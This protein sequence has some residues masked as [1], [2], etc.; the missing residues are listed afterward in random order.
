MIS[1]DETTW[2]PPEAWR[3]VLHP[4]R[5]GTVVPPPAI[6]ENA[7]ATVRVWLPSAMSR[8]RKIFDEPDTAP[9]LVEAAR[10]WIRGEA[11]PAGAAAI[12][13]MLPEVL[14]TN[15]P[16]AETLV[17]AWIGEHGLV[18][19]AEAAVQTAHVRL[20]SE[21]FGQYDRRHS[22]NYRDVK[23]VP[24]GW[25]SPTMARL[26]A[27]LA[28]TDEQTYWRAV[29]ALAEHRKTD[30]T[31]LMVSFMVP[32]EVHWVD[33][34]V[35]THPMTGYGNRLL[36]TLSSASTTAQIETLSGDP[37]FFWVFPLPISAYTVADG[38]GPALAPVI[39]TELANFPTG[40]TR[41]LLLTIL[42]EFPTDEAFGILLERVGQHLVQPALLAAMN[43]YPRRA[44]CECS[45]VQTEL[46]HRYLRPVAV[47]IT[48]QRPLPQMWTYEVIGRFH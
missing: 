29:A 37:Y 41:Q 43:R 39:A 13:T 7:S 4:R 28:A 19:A 40:A 30:F 17:D 10:A 45:C 44:Q 16:S 8:F 46:R 34:L 1:A 6:D 2:V 5:G 22:L 21:P 23:A 48:R 15:P 32:T 38:I 24:H 25:D 33:E 35:A 9:E 20:I 14:D 12:L 3:R 27:L 42:A 47:V 18:F 26:R 11:N 31:K 36:W